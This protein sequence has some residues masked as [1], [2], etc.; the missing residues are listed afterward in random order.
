VAGGLDAY[1]K[2]RDRSRTPEP[3]GDGDAARGGDARQKR[4]S[5]DSARE[6]ALF[7]IQKHA[8][9]RL[10]YDV[11]LEMGGTLKSWAVPKGPSVRHGERRLAVHVEDHPVE[12]ADFE[13]VI[14][15][16][17]YGAGEV[18][19]WDR[20]WYRSAK[21]EPL[22][23]QLARGRLEFELF[24]VKLRGRFTLVRTARGRDW[25]LLKYADAYEGGDEPTERYPESVLSGRT[26][27]EL[28][29][30]PRQIELLR[31]RLVAL[32]AP[33]SRVTAAGQ[34]PMLATLGT[35][36]F[37]RPGW[38]YEVKY[39]G[40]R[41]LAERQG[42]SLELYGRA[43][44]S[45]TARYPEI[46]AALRTLPIERFVLD[47]EVV[48]LDERG[49]PS[50][51]RLQA[52]MHLT[53]APDVGRA[54]GTTPVTG[55]F[56]DALAIDGRDLRGLPLASRK[57]CLSL[58][59]PARGVIHYGAH[60]LEQGEA[61]YDAASEQQLEGIVAK[62]VASRY[63]GGRSPDWIKIKCQ[64][65][66]EFVVGGYTSP[67]GS[68]TR[69]G[70]LHVGV[71]ERDA[72]VY[73]GRVGTGFD[74]AT[75]DAIWQRLQPLRRASSPFA[76]GT[77]TGRGHTWVEP[78]LVAEVRFTEWTDEGGIRHPAFLGL[79]ADKDPR[80]CRRERADAASGTG[81]G[82]RDGGEGLA[83][84]KLGLRG[85]FAASC[86]PFAA[87]PSPP[88]LFLAPPRFRAPPQRP[89]S[90]RS[91]GAV[92]FSASRSLPDGVRCMPSHATRVSRR[93]IAVP[94]SRYAT[95]ASRPNRSRTIAA[96]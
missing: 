69:F 6:P 9:R 8:A 78:T 62:R 71:Y 44:Q 38:L 52:R 57:E 90:R 19:V 85:R 23:A 84:L 14:P 51:Q 31:R 32:R 87:R 45:F 80:A 39:D 61:F 7:V 25:L 68:R 91:T 86:P 28:R 10:H 59:V 46:V 83:K 29:E 50:F 60:V 18:I 53:R 64:R 1:R 65:R 89:S 37:S 58:L 77:P 3:F 43:G 24:G 82:A 27:E 47:G 16:G 42:A 55:V 70:A 11:R 81:S 63:T 17:N 67:Q 66:Q 13:G 4:E 5:P 49:R 26:V 56:F 75:L 2:K 36:A 22:D 34:P 73:V 88:S 93:S 21:P 92:S 94:R 30:A 76:R 41:V 72:L 33:V 40:V 12:Y 79:R 74:G 96:R 48:A 15:R 95:R 20:G 54:R 35:H